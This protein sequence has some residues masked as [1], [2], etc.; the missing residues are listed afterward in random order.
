MQGLAWSLPVLNRPENQRAIEALGIDPGVAEPALTTTL[1]AGR[2]AMPQRQPGLPV[3]E[4]N[5]LAQQQPGHH[6]AQED[7]MTLSP[8]VKKLLE[9]QHL[10]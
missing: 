9:N 5:R 6:P 10:E 3:V 7:E 1:P 2:Q 8:R 4:T